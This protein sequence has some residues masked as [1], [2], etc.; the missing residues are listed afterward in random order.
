MASLM[1]SPLDNWV[2]FLQMKQ[3]NEGFSIFGIIYFSA[4]ASFKFGK[5]SN[6]TKSASD[7]SRAASFHKW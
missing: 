7:L 2:P 6:K 4:K 3:T 5:D 1:L